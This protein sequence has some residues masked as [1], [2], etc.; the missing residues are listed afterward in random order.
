MMK[1]IM[2]SPKN[3]DIWFASKQ[4]VEEAKKCI[5]ISQRR[6]NKF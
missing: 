6:L 2:V 4:V 5:Q 1:E 3:I